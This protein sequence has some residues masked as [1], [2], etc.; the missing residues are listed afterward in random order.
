MGVVLAGMLSLHFQQAG[1]DGAGGF[2][3]GCE[4]VG[5]RTQDLVEVR[6]GIVRGV[7]GREAAVETGEELDV[8]AGFAEGG[9]GVRWLRALGLADLSD[10][11][12]GVCVEGAGLT[13]AARPT[14]DLDR[15]HR[16]MA[17]CR[18]RFRRT[19]GWIIKHYAEYDPERERHFLTLEGGVRSYFPRNPC[20]ATRFRRCVLQT[21][22]SRSAR[23]DR[24]VG[25]R[26]QILL[27]TG[28]VAASAS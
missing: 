12:Q 8:A 15:R 18:L 3:V 27:H 5:D 17:P 11:L 28:R 25:R 16:K 4:G 20:G 7:R 23:V 9:Q 19:R 1:G 21:E 6:G 22:L 10:R 24:S 26:P 2:G 13:P 14:N